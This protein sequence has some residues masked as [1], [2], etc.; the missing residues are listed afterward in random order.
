MKRLT[1]RKYGGWGRILTCA[2][3]I[4]AEWCKEGREYR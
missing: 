3:G 1:K 4:L 2:D